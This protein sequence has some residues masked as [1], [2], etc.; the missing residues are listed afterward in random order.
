MEMVCFHYGLNL[1]TLFDVH[2]FESSADDF[3]SIL[4]N[5]KLLQTIQVTIC[6]V[7]KFTV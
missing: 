2:F 4:K 6:F 3:Y 1:F 5:Q 7:S